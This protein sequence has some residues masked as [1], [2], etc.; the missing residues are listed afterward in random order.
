M[1]RERYFPLLEV[2]TQEEC[3]QV[4]SVQY[5]AVGLSGYRGEPLESPF[6]RVRTFE[7]DVLHGLLDVPPVY[8]NVSTREG[9]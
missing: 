8:S 4:S 2:V 1:A 7:G 9:P 5:V 3:R 6:H